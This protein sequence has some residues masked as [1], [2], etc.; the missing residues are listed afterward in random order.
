MKI[1]LLSFTL[2]LFS[3]CNRWTENIPFL[4]KSPDAVVK[5]FLETSAGAKSSKDKQKISDFCAGAMK[6]AIDDM[7]DEAFKLTYLD[8]KI[9]VRE[10]K[11]LEASENGDEAKVK[12]EVTLENAGGTEPTEEINQREVEL[13]KAGGKWYVESIFLT[14]TDKV[15]FTRGMIF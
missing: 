14:G 7:S 5:I 1:F 6:A 15:A 3:A 10:I 9:T 11:I 12:Y 8:A 13:T 4:S 2:L